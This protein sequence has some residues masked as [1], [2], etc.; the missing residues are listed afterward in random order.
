MNK[1]RPFH[2]DEFGD[3]GIIIIDGEPWFIA[4]DVAA[5]LG[6]KKIDAMYRIIDEEDKRE[7]NPQTIENTG[8]PLKRGNH[9]NKPE[10]KK[11]V[12]DK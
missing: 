10:H 3:I 12:V 8:F 6:Y 11:N 4:K 2:N 7:I 1:I 9:K 5:A